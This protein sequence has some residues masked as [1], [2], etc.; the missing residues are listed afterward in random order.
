MASRPARRGHVHSTIY[1]RKSSR[2][3]G[4]H[5]CSALHVSQ[6]EGAE[7]IWVMLCGLS[8]PNH[9]CTFR[10]RACKAEQ[11]CPIDPDFSA[12]GSTVDVA[13]RAG[14]NAVLHIMSGTSAQRAFSRRTDHLCVSALAT[15][16]LLIAKLTPI[17]S[18][19][20]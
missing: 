8:S 17:A 6:P 5:A 16:I 13:S 15:V 18:V 20:R 10:L 19:N 2:V 1:L 4:Q 12:G 9:F 7:M 3:D 14:L 11:A